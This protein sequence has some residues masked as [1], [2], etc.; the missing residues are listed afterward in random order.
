MVTD[1]G[2]LF[3]V[4][5][6][7]VISQSSISTILQHVHVYPNVSFEAFKN[8]RKINIIQLQHSIKSFCH[9]N[10][11]RMK[12]KLEQYPLNF[13]EIQSINRLMYRNVMR[14][15]VFRIKVCKYDSQCARDV[16]H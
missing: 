7:T 5:R 6:E 11:K 8:R 15:S 14:N 2:N 9:Y 3:I 16:G 12:K 1:F 10:K 4:K 13:N